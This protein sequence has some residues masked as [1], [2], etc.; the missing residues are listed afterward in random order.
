MVWEGSS[1]WFQAGHLSLVSIFFFSRP[2]LSVIE[3]SQ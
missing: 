2:G 3:W 1:A